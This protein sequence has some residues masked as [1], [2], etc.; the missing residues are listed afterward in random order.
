[1]GCF[2]GFFKNLRGARYFDDGDRRALRIEELKSFHAQLA[3]FH[4]MVKVERAYIDVNVFRHI[5]REA[6]YLQRCTLANQRTTTENA[7]SFANKTY[8]DF[9]LNLSVFRDPQKISVQNDFTYGVELHILKNSLGF[10][11]LN[12][13]ANKVRIRRVD[14]LA[15]QNHRRIEMNLL[16]STV[17][18]AG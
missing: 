5:L 8:R 10:F 12:V 14:Q 4:R 9:H 18:N 16:T 6:V 11:A 3:Y 17:D 1:S 2:A 7:G 13:Q 15:E